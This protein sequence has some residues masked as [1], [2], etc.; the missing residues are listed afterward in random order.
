M[1]KKRSPLTEAVPLAENTVLRSFLSIILAVICASLFILIM[2]KSPVLAFSSLVRGA[3][4]NFRAFANTINKAVPLIFTGLAAALAFKSGLM[5]IGIEGQ[6]YIGA[7]CSVF[8][9][10]KI[11]VGTPALLAMVLC[12][13]GGMTGGACWGALIGFLKTK[14]KIHEVIVAILLNYLAI[15]FVSYIV[16]YPL[17]SAA[18]LPETDMIPQRFRFPIL[19][20]RTQFSASAFLAL[21][22]VIASYLLIYKTITGYKIRAVGSNASAAE[23]GGINVPVVSVLTMGISGILG[24]LAGTAEVLG[25]YGKLFEG[26]SSNAGFTGLAVA[27]LAGNNP[28]VVIITGLLFG[29]MDSGARQMSI[30]AGLSADM[31]IVVQGLVIFFVATPEIFRFLKKISFNRKQGAVGC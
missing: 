12:I 6:M 27:V 11:P 30:R 10:L 26:F 8:I 18:G 17:Q 9:A 29:V 2:G 7:L 20:A 15:H 25:T 5:N 31:V 13:L 19:A 21:A 24:G 23:A 4:G 16:N 14:F 22:G 28:F 1:I 3:F